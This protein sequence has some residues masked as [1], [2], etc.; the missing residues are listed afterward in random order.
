MNMR[1]PPPGYDP[2]FQSHPVRRS[3]IRLWA[4]IGVVGIV[5]ALGLLW[6]VVALISYERGNAQGSQFDVPDKYRDANFPPC[7]SFAPRGPDIPTDARQVSSTEDLH[8]GP[9]DP[10]LL[11]CTFSSSNQHGPA[12]MLQA[13]WSLTDDTATGSEKEHTNF[14]GVVSGGS[15]QGPADI[16]IGQTAR[17][18]NDT[19]GQ[20]CA[21]IV[22]D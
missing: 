15:D 20:S 10:R 9:G 5:V 8:P 19:D 12:V 11:Y 2:K 3:H 21:L 17:W 18:L 1:Y 22:L 16:G 6:G 7:A 4:I 13:N 14:V